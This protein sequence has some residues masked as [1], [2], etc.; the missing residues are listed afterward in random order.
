MPSSEG[1]VYF[2]WAGVTWQE[3]FGGNK[4]AVCFPCGKFPRRYIFLGGEVEPTPCR[5]CF[6]KS[7]RVFQT[8]RPW[9]Q[10]P[11]REKL[12]FL[13]HIWH[14]APLQIF[15]RARKSWPKGTHDRMLCPLLPQPLEILT[16]FRR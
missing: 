11:T 3:I 7:S 9:V 1:A 14:A 16:I 4:R 2:I 12:D 15:K 8:R 13:K 10:I 6:R 5:L